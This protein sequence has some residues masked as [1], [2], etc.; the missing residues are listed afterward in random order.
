MK[1]VMLFKKGYAALEQALSAAGCS[2]TRCGWRPHP[3]LDGVDAVLMHAE[4]AMTDLQTTIALKRQLRG[5]PTPIIAIDRDSPWHKGV[6]PWRIWLSKR[7]GLFDIYASHSLQGADEFSSRAL[8]F[9]NAADVSRYNLGP[10]TLADMR[11]P[12]W[13]RYDVSFVGNLDAKRYREHAARALFFQALSNRLSELGISHHFPH[14]ENMLV[15]EQVEIIQH[16]RINLNYGAAC[17]S[18]PARSW[19]LP[20]RCYGVPACGGFLLSDEREHATRDFMLGKEW[21][22]FQNLDDCVDKISY[23]LKHFAEARDIAER[24]HLRVMRDHTYTERA[25]SLL[26]AIEDWRT[27]FMEARQ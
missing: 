8:Y 17:D 2:V 15:L 25:N 20:E 16:T 7:L 13:Y 21:I 18:G 23:Y 11:A 6:K 26:A 12:D 10:Y 5:K 24:A 14:A 19:G 3:D 4:E 9:P 27:N 1:L 22:S